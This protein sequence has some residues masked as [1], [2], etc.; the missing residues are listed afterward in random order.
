MPHI[1]IDVEG[2]TIMKPSVK[3]IITGDQLTKQNADAAIRLRKEEEVEGTRQTGRL[4]SSYIADFHCSRNFTDLVFKEL[5]NTSSNEAGT[6]HQLRNLLDC[7]NITKIIL[8]K[9]FRTC[10]DFLHDVTDTSI[11]TATLHH[12]GM[13]F[14]ISS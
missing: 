3:I 12:F 1:P 6:S 7:E 8:G 14:Q 10:S 9:H 13:E 2:E 4:T 5:Y 11:T